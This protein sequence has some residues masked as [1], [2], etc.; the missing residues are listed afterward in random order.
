MFLRTL[1]VLI[2]PLVLSLVVYAALILALVLFALILYVVTGGVL[3]DLGSV[4]PLARPAVLSTVTVFAILAVL[5]WALHLT[6]LR[7]SLR[8]T[9]TSLREYSSW[10][11]KVRVAWLKGEKTA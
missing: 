1:W 4:W 11:I 3:T 9:Q 7:R 2:W 10:P 5:R 6:G 8:E